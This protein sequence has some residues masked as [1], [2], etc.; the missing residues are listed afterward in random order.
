MIR[1]DSTGGG[2]IYSHS[3]TKMMTKNGLFAH[4]VVVGLPYNANVLNHA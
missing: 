1:Y 4:Y 3:Y 2:K